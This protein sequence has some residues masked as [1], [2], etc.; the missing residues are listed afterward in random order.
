MKECC[1]IYPEYDVDKIKSCWAKNDTKAKGGKD[2][3]SKNSKESNESKG[4]KAGEMCA[5]SD[6]IMNNLGYL[7]NGVFD[8]D[9]TKA[10]I[11]GMKKDNAW[12]K[13]VS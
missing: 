5:S 2:G 8:A 4:P 7:K 11:S 12:T 1:K 10:A 3:K 9:L 13:A 6:C